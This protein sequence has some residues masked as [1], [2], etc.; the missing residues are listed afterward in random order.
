MKKRAEKRESFRGGTLTA[1]N[2]CSSIILKIQAAQDAYLQ[3]ADGLVL[4][5]NSLVPVR[6]VSFFKDSSKIYLP[7]ILIIFET[8]LMLAAYIR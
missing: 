5:I 3:W 8:F 2:S 1:S 7:I 6:S 4:E